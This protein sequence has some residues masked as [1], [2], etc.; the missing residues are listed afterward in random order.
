MRIFKRF[1]VFDIEEQTMPFSSEKLQDCIKFLKP[2]WESSDRSLHDF[3]VDCQV[4]DI[5][6]NWV[7]LMEKV[8]G[9]ETFDDLKGF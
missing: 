9:G 6:V 7:D 5:E 1:R 4:D 3:C 8:D 2:Y